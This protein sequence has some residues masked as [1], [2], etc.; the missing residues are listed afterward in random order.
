MK[1]T[2]LPLDFWMHHEMY[3]E[4][5]DVVECEPVYKCDRIFMIGEK[6]WFEKDGR[7]FTYKTPKSIKS[8][9]RQTKYRL[10]V[11][12]E[13][14]L[15]D[16]EVKALE[17]LVHFNKNPEL[18]KHAIIMLTRH[19]QACSLRETGRSVRKMMLRN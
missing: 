12:P 9:I 7:G 5:C 2:V 6:W 16:S 17:T 11:S 14:I 18:R 15:R 3:Y 19:E 13:S 1:L 8:A 10:S 4:D